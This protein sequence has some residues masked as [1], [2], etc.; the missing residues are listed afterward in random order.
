MRERRGGREGG[1]RD[2]IFEDSSQLFG[3]E[4]FVL[5]FGTVGIRGLPGGG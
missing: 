4:P 1:D 2:V 5:F 3:V